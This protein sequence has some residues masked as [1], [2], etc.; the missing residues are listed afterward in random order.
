MRRRPRRQANDALLRLVAGL[1]HVPKRSDLTLALGAADRRKLVHIAGDPAA[2]MPR[3][4]EELRTMA[5]AR[6]IDGKAHAAALAAAHRRRR[7]R[8]SR[9]SRRRAR[10]RRGAGGRRSGEPG[11]CPQQG[12]G[13]GRGRARE[14]R[15]SP[16][17]RPPA[18]PSCW[19]W[20]AQLNADP[21]VDGILVQLPLPQQIDP[22]RVH[23]RDRSGQG[24][25]RLPPRECRPAVERRQRRWCPCTPYGCLMLLRAT[26]GRARRRAK[27]W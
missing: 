16:C 2:L 15:A 7:R 9:P 20:S 14:L 13:D 21:E 11:L 24:R 6:L 12:Q 8:D 25:R 27:R 4:E 19:R 1:V 10:P 18:R 17:P 22:Q 26:L 3:L 23:R 5:Q